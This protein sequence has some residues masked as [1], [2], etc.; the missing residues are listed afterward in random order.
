MNNPDKE[1]AYRLAQQDI[2]SILDNFVDPIVVMATV[3]A[4]LKV[5]CPHFYWVGF[6]RML[7]GRLLIG[8]YQ[9]TPGCIE[10]MPDRGVCGA[11]ASRRQTIV[12]ENVE[13]F[14]GHI[15]CDSQSRSEIVVPVFDQ[16]DSLRAVLDVDSTQKGAF[17][18][19]DQAALE[20]I[21][22]WMKNCVRW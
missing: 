12:V 11:C 9:G 4:V 19:T 13:Q 3:S 5:R 10:I 2:E 21:A 8:P 22:R 14:P 17:D 15:A 1:S 7:E 18:G 16:S 6:Y 20:G